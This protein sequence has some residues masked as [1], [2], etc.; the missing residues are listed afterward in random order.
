VTGPAPGVRGRRRGR[1]L[2][3]YRPHIEWQ[4]EGAAGR[5]AVDWLTATDPAAEA[6][7]WRYLTELDLISSVVALRR[8]ADDPVDLLAADASQVNVS[9]IDGLW[10]RVLDPA[11]VLA[12]WRYAADGRVVL[13]IADD[14]GFAAGRVRLAVEGG[15]GACAPAEPGAVADVAMSVSSLGAAVLG[16]QLPL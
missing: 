2:A 12:A 1:G 11:T 15:V 14:D 9:L 3:S 6:R 7:L 10:V 5:V 16:D 8:P 13:Q 4:P